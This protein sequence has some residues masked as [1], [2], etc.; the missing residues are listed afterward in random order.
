[1]RE[2]IGQS[3]NSARRGVFRSFWMGGL[4]EHGDRVDEDFRRLKE[5]GIRTVRESL[6]WRDIERGGRCDFAPAKAVAEAAQARGLQVIWTL[7]QHGWPGDVDPLARGFPLR[8]AR[9]AAQAA[10]FVRRHAEGA[11]VYVPINEPSYLAWLA[12]EGRGEEC[13]RRWRRQLAQA[14]ILACE[15]ILDVDP[16]ARFVHAEPLMHLVPPAGRPD[17][18]AACAHGF[19][20]QFYFW[21]LLTG[22]EEPVLGGGSRYADYLGVN[23]YVGNQLELE[24]GKP[25][26][27]HL[28]DPRRA[29]LSALLQSVH[30]RYGRP[31][32]ISETG[33]HGVR[34]D[35]WVREV[36][37]EVRIARAAGVPVEGICL[38]PEV[39]LLPQAGASAAAVSV[40][41][42]FAA[43]VSSQY[44]TAPGKPAR[45]AGA[46]RQ[47][48]ATA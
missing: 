45:I 7:C 2:T 12:C 31:L 21:D 35:Y 14:A 5:F 48:R 39:P 36:D 4:A 1:M 37:D 33:H 28:D 3:A 27:W 22:S 32:L 44:S 10:R 18:A 17:L 6:G 24:S 13:T 43:D 23:Y 8:F 16:R 11:P 9:Y 25:L 34:R 30:E 40:D 20:D 41:A 42:V 38:Y 15:A 26:A 29:R 47:P 46:S 19:E